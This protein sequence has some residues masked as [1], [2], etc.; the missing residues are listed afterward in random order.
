M[1]V[2]PLYIRRAHGGQVPVKDG[3]LVN[4]KVSCNIETIFSLNI[5]NNY[6]VSLPAKDTTAI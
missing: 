6:I 5:F 2:E 1:E 3:N 4:R